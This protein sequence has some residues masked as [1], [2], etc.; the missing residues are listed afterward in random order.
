MWRISTESKRSTVTKS[1]RLESCHL[2]STVVRTFAID[3]QN[4]S[5]ILLSLIQHKAM[6]QGVASYDQ[7]DA[8]K[9]ISPLLSFV[10]PSTL[11]LTLWREE[12]ESK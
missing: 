4:R 5:K 9:F 10:L 6:N 11:F 3:V 2:H 7:S 12:M 1:A 8:L